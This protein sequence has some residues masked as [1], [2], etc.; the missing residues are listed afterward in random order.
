MHLNVKMSISHELSFKLNSPSD[1]IDGYQLVY[2][3]GTTTMREEGLNV[4][5]LNLNL[6][7]NVPGVYL[8]H[9]TGQRDKY[10]VKFIKK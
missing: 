10:V 2:S 4:D 8:L 9:V 1:K 6:S 7:G 3:N 5:Q